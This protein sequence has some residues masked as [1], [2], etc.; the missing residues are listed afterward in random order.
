MEKQSTVFRRLLKAPELLDVIA[1][2][3]AHQAQLAQLAGFKAIAISGALTSAH[4]LG[5]PDS[6]F[7]TL[8]ELVENT[9]RICRAVN[10]PVFVDADTGHG[11]AIN[12]RRTIEQL[13]RAGAA[14]CFIEDQVAPK[15]CGFVKGKELISLEE[16][17]GKYRAASDVR[18]EMD[19][20]FVLVSRTDARGAVGG[21]LE[22][23]IRRSRAYRAAG[24]DVLYVEALQNRAELRTVREAFP[25]ELLMATAIAIDPP[26][27]DEEH[28]E[29][30]LC[31]TLA[32]AATAG[33]VAQYDFLMDYKKRGQIANTELLARTRNHPM[34]GFGIFD[35]TG[36]SKVTE[37]ERKY[38]PP[39]K[40]A[41]YDSSLGLYD[42][43]SRKAVAGAVKAA[44][45]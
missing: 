27:T 29:Y 30:G 41:A 37:W 20:D 31:L 2:G 43:R 32:F 28:R 9:Q 21:S 16:A 34:G 13:I 39:E 17:V 11:N 23:A 35:L 19:P 42:P 24:V 18:N 5:M 10:I 1:V 33:S 25:N 4:I 40:L 12:V 38:L 26:L 8:T 15:R 7:L 3:T 44:S 6:G 14:G 36:F 45:D 22:E